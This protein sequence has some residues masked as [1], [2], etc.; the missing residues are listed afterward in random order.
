MISWG[1]SQA[2]E[3]GKRVYVQASLSEKAKYEKLRFEVKK[4]VELTL[5][6]GKD[7]RY[8][9]LRPAKV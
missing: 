9:M 4:L 1:L 5:D 7:E 3:A 6:G 8:L 2:D